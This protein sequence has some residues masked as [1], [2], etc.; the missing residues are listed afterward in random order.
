MKFSKTLSQNQ[1]HIKICHLKITLRQTSNITSKL[2]SAFCS[3]M[4]SRIVLQL[5]I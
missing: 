3:E 5:Q 2:Y 4:N 1:D